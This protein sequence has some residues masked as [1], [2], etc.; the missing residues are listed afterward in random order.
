[1][2]AGLPGVC[3]VRLDLG[4]YAHGSVLSLKEG[5]DSVVQRVHF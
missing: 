1:M 4:L 2:P 5:Q 3:L